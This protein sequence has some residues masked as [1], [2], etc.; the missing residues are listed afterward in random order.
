MVNINSGLN[1]PLKII[2]LPYFAKHKTK[3]PSFLLT[4]ILKA[5]NLLMFKIEDMAASFCEAAASIYLEINDLT[6]ARISFEFTFNRGEFSMLLYRRYTIV[7]D[8]QNPEA[9][10]SKEQSKSCKSLE[11]IGN[12]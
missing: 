9:E 2:K 7:D 3:T 4:N 10:I 11:I 8:V 6:R 5:N 12:E 1:V